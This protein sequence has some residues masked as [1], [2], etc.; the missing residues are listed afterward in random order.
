MIR[1]SQVFVVCESKDT[2]HC[3]KALNK[4]L[5]I[6][7]EDSE[8]TEGKNYIA[9]IVSPEDGVILGGDEDDSGWKSARPQDL[10]GELS[11]AIAVRDATKDFVASSGNSGNPSSD[12]GSQARLAAASAD[13][14]NTDMTKGLSLSRHDLAEVCVQCALRLPTNPAPTP[15]GADNDCRLRVV[16]V[17]PFGTDQKEDTEWTERPNQ[18]YFSMM[19]GKKSKARE[20][21]VTSVNWVNTL[22]PL[23]ADSDG[24][25]KEFPKRP[26][27]L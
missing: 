9:T 2:I 26:S 14:I 15:T 21:T 25:V 6:V 23:V 3:A 16:R 5:S 11:Q 13:Y 19:G 4:C 20:G 10:E 24:S 12:N 18:N 27:A 1:G 7:R 17:I 22:G 8:D